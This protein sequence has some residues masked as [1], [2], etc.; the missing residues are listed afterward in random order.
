M[1]ATAHKQESGSAKVFIGRQPIF[2]NKLNVSGYEMLFRSSGDINAAGDFDDNLATAQVI[3]NTLLEIGLDELV[4]TNLAFINFPRDLLINGTPQLLPAQRV[5]IEILENVEVD[6]ELVSSVSALAKEGFTIALDD[7]IYS[8]KWEPLIQS[9]SIIKL[10]VL[11]HSIEETRQHVNLLKNY[12]VKLLAEKVETQEE[13]DAY[14][15]M[16]FDYFQGYFFAK[17]NIIS[18]KILPDNHI[19]LLQLLSRLQDPEVDI[20]EVEILVSQTVSLSFKLFRY[21]NSAFFGLPRKLDSIRQAVVYFGMQRLKD[22]ASI[23]AMTGIGNKS[24]ELI[25]VGLTRAKMC[26]ILAELS[27]ASEKES[28]FVV[29]LFSILEALMDHPLAEIVEKLPL[30]E[31]I[32]SALLDFEGVRGEALRCSIACEQ[33]ELENICFGK[34][35]FPN[36]YDAYLEAIAWSRRAAAGLST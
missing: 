14:R 23:I 8:P 33:S 3:Y 26:E 15:E 24:S 6:N 12:N 13:Y 7:F 27:G 30:N 9:A 31:E 18:K 20:A 32:I 17:P 28:Y 4:G 21:I 11:A 19:A 29:G 35:K 34:L 1:Q 36:I 25:V 5:V 2:N 10:D 22:L 16:G